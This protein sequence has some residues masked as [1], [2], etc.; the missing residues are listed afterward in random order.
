MR[1][2]PNSTLGWCRRYTLALYRI[3]KPCLRSARNFLI[4]SLLLSREIFFTRER[5]FI[6]VPVPFR[7][8]ETVFL[9]TLEQN[10]RERQFL[11]NFPLILRFAFPSCSNVKFQREFLRFVKFRFVENYLRC[12][13]Y[14]LSLSFSLSL[15][16]SLSLSIFITV[17]HLRKRN[18]RKKHSKC[19]SSLEMVRQV[20]FHPEVVFIGDE[21][22]LLLLLFFF[23]FSL[24]YW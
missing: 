2:R 6:P 22:L 18:T 8:K 19:Y 21:E 7:C 11:E 14:P 13:I 5:I 16:L 10:L 4:P 24:W 17:V 20:S 3:F 15:S 9:S 12:T 23:F 1:I